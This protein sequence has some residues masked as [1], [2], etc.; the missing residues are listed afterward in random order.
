MTNTKKVFDRNKLKDVLKPV[1]KKAYTSRVLTKKDLYSNTLDPFSAVL[2]AKLLGLS[3][4]DWEEQVERPRQTQKT[5]Q[6]AIGEMHQ[7]IIATLDDWEDLGTGGVVD[8][9]NKKKKILA[10]IKNKWNTVNSDSAIGSY[11]GLESKIKEHPGFTGYHVV[12]LP[13]NGQAF[14]EEFTP[15]D[16]KTKKK[17]PSREDIRRIDG[18]S[19]Y[20][21][22]T[23]QEDAFQQLYDEFHSLIDE[24]LTEE[25]GRNFNV[26]LG[27]EKKEFIFK[28]V[29]PDTEEEE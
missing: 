13:K 22:I 12:M 17:R 2:D 1:I 4:E 9:R 8:N 10:E 21:E 26:D 23:G 3:L 18:K 5:I 15:S 6:N 14:D 11:D 16:K 19:F 20:K 24:V 27:N 25:T 29:F 7:Q 28:K